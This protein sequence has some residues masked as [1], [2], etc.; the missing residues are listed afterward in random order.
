MIEA[1]TLMLRSLC[2]TLL[3]E[4]TSFRLLSHR[5]AARCVPERSSWKNGS[6]RRGYKVVLRPRLIGH[7][8]PAKLEMLILSKVTSAGRESAYATALATSS[9]EII[10]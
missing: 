2:T 5:P 10:L 6:Q 8:F 7:R 9:G 3:I 4:E 1:I